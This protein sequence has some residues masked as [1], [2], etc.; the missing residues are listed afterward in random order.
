MSKKN[1][2]FLLLLLFASTLHAQTTRPKLAVGIVVDQMRPEYLYRFSSGF[3]KGG[4]NRLLNEGFVCYNT[5]VDYMPTVT[6]PGHASIYTGTTPKYHGICGNYWF[7]RNSH[8]P[9]YCAKDALVETVGNDKMEKGSYSARNILVPTLGDVLKLT[10]AKH[11]KV[12]AIS[13]KDRSAAFP[14]GHAADGAFWFDKKTGNFISSTYYMASL[15]AWLIHFNQSGR[16]NSYLDSI[17]KPM[18]KAD[19]YKFSWPDSTSARY[20]IGGGFLFLSQKKLRET[21]KPKNDKYLPIYASP[22]GNKLLADL[23]IE[24]IQHTDIGKDGYPDLLAIS[25]SSTDVVGHAY[26]PVSKELNDTYIRLD[27]DLA[28]V[29]D[30][31]DTNVG[32]GNYV[33]FLTADHGMSDIPALLTDNKI[34]GGYFDGAK[35]EAQ[36]DTAFEKQYGAGHWV[37]TIYEEQVYLNRKLMA[38]KNVNLMDAQNLAASM[39]REKEGIADVFTADQ[40][41]RYDYSSSISG[42][43]QKGFNYMR[44]GDVRMVFMPGWMDSREK[45]D[46]AATHGSGFNSDTNIPLLWFGAGIPKGKSYA[47]YNMTDIAPTVSSL[48]HI[49]TP[50]AATGNPISEVLK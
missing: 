42:R 6:G 39:V 31:L 32:K 46:I 40:L 8:K 41:T 43:V 18:G 17:W 45:E 22:F 23:A 34:P 25:F 21:I 44:C 2:F 27:T 50:S 19:D 29:L 1:F 33:L 3:G 38:E 30:A 36:L 24:T 10:T 13:M 15:P 28:R 4:F 11:G 9:V 35:L 49:I 47:H 5:H 7:D 37:D 20:G 16:A 26:G 14:A 12:Y 48:L